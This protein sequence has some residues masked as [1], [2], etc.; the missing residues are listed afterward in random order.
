MKDNSVT[1]AECGRPLGPNDWGYQPGDNYFAG[2]IYCS[3]QCFMD[4]VYMDCDMVEN[5][6]HD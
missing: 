2:E 3:V 1:C 5:L 4:S 6:D